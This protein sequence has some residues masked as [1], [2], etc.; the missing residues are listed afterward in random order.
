MTGACV[1]FRR[2]PEPKLSV[3]GRGVLGSGLRRNDA[4]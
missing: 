2:R 4:L 3:T 1:S